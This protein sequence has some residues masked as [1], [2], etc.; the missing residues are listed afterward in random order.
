VCDTDAVEPDREL[1]AGVCAISTRPSASMGA[2]AATRT[3]LM[4]SVG[5]RATYAMER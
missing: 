5:T 2:Q 4:L 1:V 3:T